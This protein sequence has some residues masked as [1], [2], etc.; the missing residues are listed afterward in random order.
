[1]IKKITKA[2]VRRFLALLGVRRVALG[3]SS[4]IY[5]LHIPLSPDVEKGWKPYPLFN[6][7]TVGLY[8][9]S[10]H[11]SVLVNNHCPHPPHTH[12]EEEILL[13]L[14]GEVDIILPQLQP[15]EPN[16]RK[17]LKPG[18]LVYYPAQ[19]A[20]TLQTVSQEPA[21]YLM[22]RWLG[23]LK[24]SGADLFF[25][26][27]DLFD[28]LKGS[29]IKDGFW[30]KLVFEGTTG[31]LKKVHCHVSALSPGAGYGAHIDPYAVA[32]IVLEGEVKTLGQ[33]AVPH[34]LIFYAPGEPHSMF[35]PG[36]KIARYVVFEFHGRKSF[37]QSLVNFLI[38]KTQ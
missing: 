19:F 13:L 15:A 34:N 5:P 22:F 37:T 36:N 9:L 1:M 4:R 10:C 18:Q 23:E 20:H 7:N 30:S 33:R 38:T 3:L 35:N 27:F 2:I 12:N 24:K 21:D 6:G 8:C 25:G 28:I 32:I 14:G 31:Y 11:T 16:Y 17:R 26:Y 29:N